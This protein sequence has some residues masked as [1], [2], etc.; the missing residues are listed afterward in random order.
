MADDGDIFSQ[1][2]FDVPK[3]SA[4][5][6]T[7]DDTS[8]ATTGAPAK[9]IF[10]SAGFK[11]SSDASASAA[12]ASTWQDHEALENLA[13]QGFSPAKESAAAAPAKPGR[14]ILRALIDYPGH[15]LGEL[16]DTAEIPGN[17]LASDK[18]STS[19]SLIPGA[20]AL[21]GLTTGSEFPKTAG[22][23]ALDAVKPSTAA[24]NALVKAVGPENV[25]EAINALRNNPRLTLADVSDPVRLST[26]GLMAG[27]TPDV[28]GFISNAVR[29]RA[30]SRLEAANTA[31]TEAMGP[32]PDVTQMVAGLKQR[33]AQAADDH[34]K[35]TESALDRV[36]GPSTDP[37]QVLQD[38][39][40]KRS[41][42]AQPLYEKALAH[43]VAW[44]ERL[45]Q[46]IDDPIVKSGIAKGVQ[47]QRLESLAEN[48]PFNPN[49]FAIKGFNEAGDPIISQTP[50]M[51]TLNV[52]KKGL[53][54]MVD[55]SKDSVTGRLS[56]QGRAID[57]VRS[58]F[59][60]KLDD[61][62]PDYKA[63]R[64]AWAGPSQAQD[65]YNR[66]LNIF[67]NQAGS[68]G[69]K[70]TPEALASWFN[71]ASKAEQDAVK[72]G[73][74]A[75]LNHQMK[76]VGDPA[77]RASSLLN[78]DVNQAKFATL[79]GKENADSLTKQLNFHLE[80]P[81]GKAF[82]GGFDVLK[83][84]SGV[85]G[86]EDRPEFLKQ[87]MQGATP[88]EVVAKRLGVRLDIDQ[89]IN[90]VKNGALAGQNV[91]AIPYNQEKLKTLFGDKEANRLI[92]VMQDAKREADT[93]AAIFSGSK[94]AETRAAADR[95]KVREVG[96]GNPLQYVA[97]VAAEILGQSAGLP[98]AG[99]AA[100]LAAKGIHMGAQKLGQMHDIATNMQMARSA[101]ATGPAREQTINAL[102]SH[103]K[104]AREFK[105]RA[106][107]LTAP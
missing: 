12:P 44:D 7:S 25:P 87:W 60:Q 17:V 41:E 1:A 76:T 83:N 40:K 32:A 107:A 73:A 67:Q 8:S 106:N 31:Y 50:N 45:Q 36:M 78:K 9:S 2:G 54:A 56:E 80:D 6:S 10:E 47:I 19:A 61:I 49:D 72:I 35:S 38:T 66:G 97:P 105:K 59:L 58:A 101:L 79:F 55:E 28:Q 42:E 24:T 82:D 88:E 84:R 102:L 96:G 18:P 63:A 98:G 13:A 53:D 86:L 71:G 89:K 94:T 104:V 90:S 100:S 14:G 85:T 3:A 62:N 33:A 64:Q 74:R 91:T 81:V 103:P 26:Q 48:K 51:R 37:Y 99:L 16:K 92:G 21:A 70:S 20:V 11:L 27:G 39:M 29:D 46:F 4:A 65:A 95:I 43:P 68:S 69:V 52:V 15:V 23:A 93:N 30:G 34:A 5:A 77:S 22:A 57:K 75:A